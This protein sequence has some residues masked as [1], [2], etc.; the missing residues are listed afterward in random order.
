MVDIDTHRVV[1][2]PASRE[3]EDV[4]EW[5]RSCPNIRIVSRDGSVSYKS[6]IEQAGMDIQQVSDR[7]HLLKG[8]T[9]AAKKFISRLLSAAFTL[10]TEASHYDG[11]LT[12]DYWDKPIKEDSPTAEHNANVEKKMKVVKQVREL[13]KQGLNKGEIAGLAGINRATVAK[14]LK[15]DFNP[16]NPYYNTAIPSKIKPYAETIILNELVNSYVSDFEEDL[17]KTDIICYTVAQRLNMYT[18]LY[19]LLESEDGY[20]SSTP[21]KHWRIRTGIAQ[22]DTSLTTEVNLAL[23]L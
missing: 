21:A 22:S 20:R 18:P 7:F 12:G 6:A 11:K 10:P 15:E 9:D 8:L 14:Y 3:V 2:L 19:Y 4:A 13:R 5:L 23:A 17:Q 1:D 16:A